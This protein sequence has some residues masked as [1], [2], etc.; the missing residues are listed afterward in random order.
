MG[1]SVDRPTTI[2]V[3]LAWLVL[4]GASAIYGYHHTAE[5]RAAKDEL[6]VRLSRLVPPRSD[7]VPT[8]ALPS[9]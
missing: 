6:S 8:A 4:S 3:G 5:C 1:K 2:G 7:G 9:N